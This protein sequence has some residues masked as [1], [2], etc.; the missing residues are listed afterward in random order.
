MSSITETRQN[1]IG[2]WA[3]VEYKVVN[4]ETGH[5]TYPMGSN[6]QGF[7]MYS[8]DGF[9]SANLMK[10]GAPAFLS[11]D[12]VRGTQEELSEAMKHYLGYCGHYD[13]EEANGGIMVKHNMQVCSFPNWIGHEQGRLITFNG[14]ILEINTANAVNMCTGHLD[15]KSHSHQLAFD[16]WGAQLASAVI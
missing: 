3:L 9:V 16:A 8:A 10:P 14:N 12:R 13:L 5:V 15:G 2:T 1:L 11:E 4:I 7:L 6:V